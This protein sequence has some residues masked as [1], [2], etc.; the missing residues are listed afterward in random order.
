MNSIFKSAILEQYRTK[1][2]NYTKPNIERKGL[3]ILAPISNTVESIEDIAT[4]ANTI[5]KTFNAYDEIG[6]GFG[7]WDNP[8][9][10][11][12]T[13]WTITI[14]GADYTEVPNIDIQTL[15]AAGAYTA[16]AATTYSIDSTTGDITITAAGPAYADQVLTSTGTFTDTQTVVVGSK[17]YTSQTVLTNVDGNFLIG[18]SAAASHQ[19]LMDAINLTGTAGTQY[20]ALM[21]LNPDAEATAVTATTNTVKAKL[22]GTGGNALTSTT[23]QANASWGAATFAGGTNVGSVGTFTVTAAVATDTVVI[24]GRTYTYR[25]ALTTPAVADEL[26]IGASATTSAAALVAA[27]NGGDGEGVTYSTGT[28]HN[29]DVWGSNIAGVVTVTSRNG[30]A[31]FDAIT[32]TETGANL[33][34]GA[35]TLGSGAGTD[36]RTALRVT[37]K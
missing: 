33:A 17:T 3:G 2:G 10:G 7:S 24:N 13:V 22:W 37:I 32:T 29:V 14:P 20:A 6:G 8:A 34:W 1:M 19:N 5:T 11:T 23:T 21:T 18:A 26:L 9:D 31:A 12:S 16:A 36:A 30:G 27:L 25:A 4:T 35:G 15:S 28:S